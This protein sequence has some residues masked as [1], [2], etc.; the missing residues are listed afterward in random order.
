MLYGLHSEH[1]NTT[2]PSFSSIIREERTKVSLSLKFIRSVSTIKLRLWI[3]AFHVDIRFV[4]PL[5]LTAP[6]DVH[7][8][9]KFVQSLHQRKPTVPD[10]FE[11]RHG[12][13]SVNS[14]Q[15]YPTMLDLLNRIG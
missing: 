11:G 6:T 8:W 7:C 2:P 3:R 1:T 9:V 13:C 10:M 4:L 5:H 15:K 12:S 14:N